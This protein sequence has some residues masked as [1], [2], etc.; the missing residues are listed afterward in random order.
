[1]N[2]S[3]AESVEMPSAN[4][5]KAY[6]W[7]DTSRSSAAAVSDK[8]ATSNGWCQC[9]LWSHSPKAIYIVLWWWWHPILCR[10]SVVVVD[11]LAISGWLCLMGEE[12]KSLSEMSR[13]SARVH[14]LLLSSPGWRWGLARTGLL[15]G[16]SWE[17][18]PWL[19]F[20]REELLHFLI[21]PC[22]FY[23][24]DSS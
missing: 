3:D 11:Q 6:N 9:H 12:G 2:S 22:P 19:P 24:C 1:M 17:I 20:Q 8:I 13:W 23:I 18:A 21:S 4:A 5:Q 16:Q 14:L 15:T 10:S 7:I